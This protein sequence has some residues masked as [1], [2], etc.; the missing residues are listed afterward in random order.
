M[1]TTTIKHSVGK[2]GRNDSADVRIVQQL[3]RRDY[4]HVW[5][6]PD[7][8]V[9]LT[10]K[11]DE[12]TVAA[13]TKFQRNA[14]G[15]SSPD[16][17]VKPG[18]RTWKNL[19]RGVKKGE[20]PTPP[21]DVKWTVNLWRF[22]NCLLYMFDE[23]KNNAAS[24]T[25]ASIKALNVAGYA[26]PASKVA[27]LSAWALKVRK[28]AEWDHK[29]KLRQRLALD[30]FNDYHFPISGDNEH[31][32]FYDIW[33]N[34]HYGYV[35]RAAG[36]SASELQLGAASPLK[37]LSGVNDP[38][39][40]VTIQIG[41]DLWNVHEKSMTM[42]QLHQ[43]LLNRKQQILQVQSTQAYLNTISENRRS[44]WRHVMKSNNG[45]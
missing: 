42:T 1:P 22:H 16:G 32:W 25:V 2:G 14:I 37:V 27:A 41:V 29:P 15:M 4:N 12:Q 26:M 21:D 11:V 40:V 31:E 43:A 36:F 6:K 18:L 28:N 20:K 34:I 5:L 33:S 7:Q 23:M 9:P 8:P 19:L 38:M 45:E 17:L 39:D 24:T 35:G 13:I 10:G 44:W 3:L 30:K